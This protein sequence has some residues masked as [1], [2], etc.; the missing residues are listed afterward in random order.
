MKKTLRGNSFHSVKGGVGKST[1][2]THLALRLARE[3]GKRPTFLID[4]DLTGTSLAD[5]LPLRAPTWSDTATDGNKSSLLRTQPRGF[6]SRAET[7]RDMD[8]RDEVAHMG[9]DPKA[10]GLSGA[11][12]LP[13]LNDYL[14]FSPKDWRD[15]EADVDPHSLL[16]GLDLPDAPDNLYVLPSSAL[17]S[18]LEK[19]LPVVFD[20]HY[21]G[22]LENRFELLLDALLLHFGDIS[23]V[24]DTPPTIPGLSRAVLNLALRLG[25]PGQQKQALV[26]GG[27][28]PAAIEEAELT[29]NAQLVTTPD[30]QD[31][32][33]AA[34]WYSLTSPAEREVIGFLF[35]RVRS[36]RREEVLAHLESLFEAGHMLFA[37]PWQFHHYD[38]A[39]QI[40][41]AEHRVAACEGVKFPGWLDEE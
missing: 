27:R 31:V 34:R 20:E 23:V 18:D 39:V 28:L 13:F 1:L 36:G 5:V 25:S 30:I 10:A 22:F 16:W 35:N 32:R 37:V 14:L 24:V 2:A 7:L 11:S 12:Y 38:P 9:A 15:A 21:A 33:A 6:L 8:W 4:M 29:W 3:P 41:D 17:P 26:Q 40:F 19:I